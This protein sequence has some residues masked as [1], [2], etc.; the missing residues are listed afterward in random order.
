[1]KNKKFKMLNYYKVVGAL[2]YVIGLTL[3]IMNKLVP[4]VLGNDFF[5]GFG[6]GLLIVAIGLSVIYLIKRKD[7]DFADDLDASV[8]DERVIKD[9][10][11]TKAILLHI[12]IAELAI[13]V[14]ISVFYEFEFSIGGTIMLY[15]YILS[16]AVVKVYRKL[17]KK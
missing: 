9:K 4:D 15:T 5:S 6:T 12:L 7:K 11:E 2:L 13:M 14:T 10:L 1:M 17:R 16:F 3:I 8:S